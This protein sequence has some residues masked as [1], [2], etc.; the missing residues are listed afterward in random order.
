MHKSQNISLVRYEY[1]VYIHLF[2]THNINEILLTMDDFDDAK[3]QSDHIKW[4]PV[5]N[6]DIDI[7]DFVGEVRE[8]VEESIP[9]TRNRICGL[10]DAEPLDWKYARIMVGDDSNT[11]HNVAIA[12]MPRSPIVPVIFDVIK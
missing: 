4:I 2:K 11:K 5:E 8:G 10:F 6:I 3:S 7:I 9:Q 1:I 12:K